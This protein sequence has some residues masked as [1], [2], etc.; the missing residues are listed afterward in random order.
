MGR[1]EHET[2]GLVIRFAPALHR[3]I[4]ANLLALAP[5]TRVGVDEVTAQIG[6]GGMGQVYR[7]TDTALGRQVA[8]KILPDTFAADLPMLHPGEG[9]ELFA[10]G[11][12]LMPRD[13]PYELFS[14]RMAKRF[15]I[16]RPANAAENSRPITVVLNC[17]VAG[18]DLSTDQSRS[19]ARTARFGTRYGA[20]RC[21]LWNLR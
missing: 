18:L 17:L 15:L 11:R 14:H 4:T 3:I 6:E 2:Q 5:G 20:A 16:P 8:I 9:A 12:A 21:L 10:S 7:A 1:P 13:T 19:S